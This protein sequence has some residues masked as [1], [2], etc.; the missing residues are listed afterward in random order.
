[1]IMRI[2]W[3]LFLSRRDFESHQAGRVPGLIRRILASIKL[4]STYLYIYIYI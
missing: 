3:G 2:T 1:M 4:A